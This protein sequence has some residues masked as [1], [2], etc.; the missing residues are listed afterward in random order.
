MAKN[1][2]E[3]FVKHGR[4]DL[5][6]R[7]DKHP[8][9]GKKSDIEIAREIV[10]GEH[11]ELY[12]KMESLTGAKKSTYKEPTFPTE[13]IK[14]INDKY[15]KLVSDEKANPEKEKA[16]QDTK[17]AEDKVSDNAEVDKDS[18]GAGKKP[19]E[20]GEKVTEAGDPELTKIA[21]AVNDQLVKD[22]FGVD[23]LDDIIGQLQDTD[24]SKTYDAVKNRAKNDLTLTKRTREKVITQKGGNAT[25]QAVLLYDMAQLKGTEKDLRRQ[26]IDSKDLQEREKLQ[27]RLVEVQNEMMDN[28][29]ANRY[30]GRDWHNIGKIR[31]QWINKDFNIVDMQNEYM[32]SKGIS[33]L[34]PE[35]KA[36]IQKFHDTIKDLEVQRDKAKEELDKAVEENSRLQAENEILKKLKGK[37]GKEARVKRTDEQIAKSNERIQKAKD[38]LRKMRGE[39]NDITRVLPKTALLIGKMAAEKVYQGAIEFRE[40]VRDILDEVKDIFPEWGEKDVAAHLLSETANYEKYYEAGKK[41]DT[42]NKELQ[43]KIKAYNKVQKEYA[44]KMFEWQKD[45]RS[46]IMSKRPFREKLYDGLLRWQRFAVLTYPSTIAK[47]IGVVAHQLTFKPIKF[48]IQKIIGSVLPKS[49]TSKQ[50][51][52]GN[53]TWRSIGKYYSAFVNNFTLANLK[54]Q[55]RGI[56]T[57]EIL[58]GDSFMYDEWA[59]SKGILE[60]PG[61]SHGYIK[62]FIKNPEFKYAQENIATHYITK[63]AEIE[64]E[65]KGENITPEKTQELKDEYAKWDITDPDVM[66][67]INKLS[68][69][70]G[71]WG[72]LMND[73]KFVDSF[74]RWADARGFW[75]FLVRSEMP[76]IKIPVNYVSRA[77]A[78]KYG[79]IRAMVGKGKWESKEGDK[80]FPGLFEIIAKGTKDLTPQQADLLGKAL[81]IGTMGAAFFAMGYMMRKNIKQNDDGSYDIFGIHVNKNFA[82][83]PE[84]ESLFSGAE[85][86]NTFDSDKNKKNW[87]ESYVQADIDI[88]KKSPFT[89]M[90]KYGFVP[91]L[92]GAFLL[93]DESKIQSKV[94][95]AVAKK[96]TDMFVPGLVKQSASAMDVPGKNFDIFSH[97]TNRWPKGSDLERF[98]QTFELGIPGLRQNVPLSTKQSQGNTPREPKEAKEPKERK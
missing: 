48:A 29:L 40:L 60:L 45:R 91:N 21:N 84:L 59:A 35:Q 16:T 17:Q 42:N 2:I 90:L 7:F 55:F 49:I 88:A 51:L 6:D 85:T 64:N 70:H 94:T 25:D 47:L 76:I 28:S 77:F 44:L 58:Y 23:A 12:Q 65:L 33:E 39:M 56:D 3:C 14:E 54:E 22:K 62:S 89:S 81:N 15:D 26:I 68:L 69:E 8:D 73:N 24:L 52:W 53:P 98:W 92:A 78:Y 4:P 80:S 43:E 13:K 82:H 38:E 36:E 95:D 20:G 31:Q 27:R 10:L 71:K 97:P 83:S 9:K 18:G 74:R 75:G 5:Q 46:D 66:E 34:S 86:G 61:R 32:A 11:K 19:P 50:Q 79:L 96:L 30:I 93:K 41:Y 72:I 87:L 37:A 63:M 67:R 57:K 1:P